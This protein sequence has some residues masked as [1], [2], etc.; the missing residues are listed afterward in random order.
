MAPLYETRGRTPVAT[1]ALVVVAAAVLA[2]V[3]AS[4]WTSMRVTP[5]RDIL[6]DLG[7]YEGKAV[8]VAGT[9]RSGFSLFGQGAYPLDDGTGAIWIRQHR[10]VP[11]PGT[12]VRV[13]GTVEALLQIGDA[14]VVSIRVHE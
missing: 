4:V 6:D 9:V 10:P 2:V 11:Q 8:N 1:V 7:R 12:R 13:R 14:S 5:V 3:G